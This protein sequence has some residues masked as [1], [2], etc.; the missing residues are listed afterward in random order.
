MPII[1]FSLSYA[2]GMLYA[3][4]DREESAYFCR[5]FDVEPRDM[6]MRSELNCAAL[7]DVSTLPGFLSLSG[8]ALG[9]PLS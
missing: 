7:V 3:F 1:L 2:A 4:Y 5:T 8:D 9:K 6:I